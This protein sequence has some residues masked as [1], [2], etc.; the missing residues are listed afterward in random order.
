VNRDAIR[1]NET[2]RQVRQ[3]DTGV[4]VHTA[5]GDWRAKRVVV[6]TPLAITGRIAFDPP[7]PQKRGQL[8]DSVFMGITVKVVVAYERPFWRE[9]KLS[10]QAVG[11]SGMLSVVFDDTSTDGRVSCLLGFV[12]G[13]AARSFCELPLDERRAKVID[14]L[15][16]FFG[17]QARN[18]IDYAETDWSNEEFSGGCP[19]GLFATRTLT[20]CGEALRAPVGR[21]H[22]A[23]TETA[24]QCVGYM[25]GAVESGDR[26]AAEVLDAL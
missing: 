2:V 10:G 11:T 21:I 20:T 23:G 15:A 6:S 8:H 25:E 3:G 13:R 5:G 24:R 12:V 18:P 17:D 9:Q 14:E 19:T 26:A 7:L 1:L 22:W 16:R 4:S